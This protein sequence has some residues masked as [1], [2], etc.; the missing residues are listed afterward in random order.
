MLAGLKRLR[1]KAGLT[2]VELAMALGSKST[3]LVSMWE[4]GQRSPRS[5]YLPKIAEVL[6]C[7]ID[8]LYKSGE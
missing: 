1:K 3:G 7:S 5:K 6:G 8:E 2:Q 4:T